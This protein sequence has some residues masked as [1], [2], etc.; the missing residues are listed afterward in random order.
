MNM[1]P[2]AP[3]E[4]IPVSR[5]TA[6]PDALRDPRR[7]EWADA[8]KRGEPGTQVFRAY[9]ANLK[10]LGYTFPAEYKID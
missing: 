3:L 7:C 1:N 2:F 6:L 4:R 10:K 9:I 5:F 8:N